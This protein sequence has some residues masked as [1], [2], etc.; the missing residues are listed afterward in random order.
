MKVEPGE[1][2]AAVSFVAILGF[3]LFLASALSGQ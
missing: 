1:I 2:A 3:F